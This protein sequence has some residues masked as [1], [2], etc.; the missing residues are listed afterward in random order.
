MHILVDSLEQRPFSF[1]HPVRVVRFS[2]PDTGDYSIE[3]LID[4][5]RIERKRPD[6]LWGC[7]GYK[8]DSFRDQLQRLGRFEFRLLVVE[9]SVK[10]LAESGPKG[11]S[12][13]SWSQVS[14]N[15]MRWTAEFG[16]PVWFLGPRS[17]ETCKL[18]EC[19]L[20]S[21]HEHYIRLVSFPNYWRNLW[22]NQSN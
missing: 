15:L 2:P 14:S 22:R 13:M 18:L 3:G 16:V 6:E 11:K 5:L 4:R 9:G 19:L 17:P 1:V 7:C 10:D 21:L 12:T 8:R 20:V